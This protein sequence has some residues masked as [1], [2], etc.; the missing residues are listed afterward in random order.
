MF[1]ALIYTLAT[2]LFMSLGFRALLWHWLL[3]IAGMGAGYSLALRTNSR[4]PSLGN[5]HLIESSLVAVGLLLLA[6]WRAKMTSG[7]KPPQLTGA[8]K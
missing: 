1:L 8:R 4:L 6:G 5:M 2:H 3:A 7:A